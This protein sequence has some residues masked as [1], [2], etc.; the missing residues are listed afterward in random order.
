MNFAIW[1]IRACPE[2]GADVL[3]WRT[4]GQSRREWYDCWRQY[5]F[6]RSRGIAAQITYAYRGPSHVKFGAAGNYWVG[7]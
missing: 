7:S 2:T 5:R 6:M 4:T 3:F 1:K